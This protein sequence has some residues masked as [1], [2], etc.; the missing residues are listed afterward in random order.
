MKFHY[1][2]IPFYKMSLAHPPQ[3]HDSW[4]LSFLVGIHPE[5][6][7][8]RHLGSS[9]E[10]KVVGCPE[11]SLISSCTSPM[12]GLFLIMFPFQTSIKN[13]LLSYFL[14]LRAERFI[15]WS[16]AISESVYSPRK[17]RSISCIG[18]LSSG[19]IRFIMFR[20]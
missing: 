11:T 8:D 7:F 20:W 9:N 3:S 2:S 13:S 14:G 12:T 10:A 1:V 6:K 5:T 16:I 19:R 4:V 15:L 18:F 17:A